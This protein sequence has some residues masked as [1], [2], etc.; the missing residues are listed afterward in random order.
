MSLHQVSIDPVWA[1]VIAALGASLLTILGTVGIERLRQRRAGRD[2]QRREKDAAYQEVLSR[3]LAFANRS[4]ALGDMMRIRSGIAEGLGVTLGQRRPAD[5][6]EIYE[7][8][9]K[10]FG[11]LL[12]AWSREAVGTVGQTLIDL[13]A[14]AVTESQA[15]LVVPDAE[16]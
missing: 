1:P 7:W 4:R 15:I 11:P 8:M 12:S 6:F 3:S 14:E 5:A 9:D 10:D 2:A 16:P 13:L